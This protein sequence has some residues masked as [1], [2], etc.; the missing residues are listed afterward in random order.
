MIVAT[1]TDLSTGARF[2]Y[3]QTMFDILCSD[4]ASVRLSRAAAS[5]SAV[6]V[7]LSPVTL[8]NYGGSCGYREPP[9]LDL[10]ANGPYPIRPAAR[11]MQELAELRT[12][13]NGKARPYIH[14]VDGG[15]ADNLAM[16][17]VLDIM[18]NVEALRLIGLPTPID[19]VKR[20]VVIVVNSLSKPKTDWDKDVSAPGTFAVL[21]KATGVPI[22]HYSYEAVELLRDTA[23]RWAMLRRVRDSGAISEP[24]NP[25]LLEVMRVPNA[26]IYVVN[27]S[28]AELKDAAEREFL[29]G[30]PTSF[31]LS[32]E[33][34][35]RLRAAAGSLVRSSPEFRRFL[36]DAGFKV[37]AD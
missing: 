36:T 18:D 10:I 32:S 27:V 3:T 34:V 14:L 29:N 13:E 26:E 7:V 25:A 12:Y 31:V 19:R 15:V 23:A 28:F 17:G 35:D 6:P 4:L 37:T 24:A 22:E 21:L 8:N 30:L 16:R 33:A 5:S 1:A 20:I 9:W 11:S 2:Y